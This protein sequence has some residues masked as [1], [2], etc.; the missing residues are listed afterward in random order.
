M[1]ISSKR[2]LV[3]YSREALKDIPMTSNEILDGIR[4]SGLYSLRYEP[5]SRS[6]SGMLRRDG[7]FISVGKKKGNVIWRLK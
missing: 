7:R 5:S 6:L 1:L 4:E 2:I 3:E